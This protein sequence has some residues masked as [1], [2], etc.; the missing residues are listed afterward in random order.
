MILLLKVISFTPDE[1]E[2]ADHLVRGHFDEYG[3][4]NGAV[5]IYGE[6]VEN[7]VIPWRGARGNRTACGPF[8]INFAA[9]EGDGKH[10]TLPPEDPCAYDSENGENWR[11]VPLS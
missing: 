5:S 7:H 9:V 6:S 11:S 3:Q 2:N 4:F 1:F 8:A 10:S